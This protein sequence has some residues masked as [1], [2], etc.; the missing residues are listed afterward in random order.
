LLIEVGGSLLE[1]EVPN[2]QLRRPAIRVLSGTAEILCEVFVLGQMKENANKRGTN[3]YQK[4][5]GKDPEQQPQPYLQLREP[6]APVYRKPV[7][8]DDADTYEY[9]G[10][11]DLRSSGRP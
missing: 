1:V 7:A 5:V 8:D 4:D 3:P 11:T 10:E 2:G 9:V 6:S